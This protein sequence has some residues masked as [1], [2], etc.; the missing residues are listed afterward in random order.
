MAYKA[1]NISMWPFIEKVCQPPK[2]QKLTACGLDLIYKVYFILPKLFYFL[3]KFVAAYS[4]VKC[5]TQIEILQQL[6]ET[7]WFINQKSS[8]HR[9]ANQLAVSRA[10]S[11]VVGSFLRGVPGYRF[12]KSHF[13]SKVTNWLE[14]KLYFHLFKFLKKKKAIY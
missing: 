5:H 9:A 12:L 6:L 13:C 11:M 8:F 10:G 4:Y 2:D 14:I 3:F 1:W 7:R